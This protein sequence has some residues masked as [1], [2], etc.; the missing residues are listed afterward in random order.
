MRELDKLIEG[1]YLT[2]YANLD[3]EAKGA[4]EDLLEEADPDLLSWLTV[5]EEPPQRYRKMIDTMRTLGRGA[6][7]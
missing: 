1:Y 3:A 6:H 4:F 5:R 2:H 7:A